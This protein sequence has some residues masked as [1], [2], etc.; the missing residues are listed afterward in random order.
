MIINTSNIISS[1][2]SLSPFRSFRSSS[3]LAFSLSSSSS[4]S[5]SSSSRSSSSSSTTSSSSSSSPLPLIQSTNDE[6]IMSACGK[7][8]I[9]LDSKHPEYVIN[10]PVT[11]N[12]DNTDY[13]SLKE[14]YLLSDEMIRK[15]RFPY[16]LDFYVNNN[17]PISRCT[18]K[19]CLIR[20]DA[21]AILVQFRT[22]QINHYQSDSGFSA[23]F[24]ILPLS[25]DR[26]N[27]SE[28]KERKITLPNGTLITLAYRPGGQHGNGI[29]STQLNTVQRMPTIL[30]ETENDNESRASNRELSGTYAVTQHIS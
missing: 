3:F 6:E 29:T 24:V 18:S 9:I 5:P 7:R 11:S 19:I 26:K 8:H 12:F 27:G 22:K 20:S 25:S 30:E 16:P 14:N 4:S 28:S 10:F 23:K 17:T 1:S 13:Q 21:S 15:Q 2:L